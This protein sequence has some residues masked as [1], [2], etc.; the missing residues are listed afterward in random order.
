MA[1][2]EIGSNLNSVRIAL[3]LYLMQSVWLGIIKPQNIGI[4]I[5]WRNR[6]KNYNDCQ[7][8]YPRLASGIS[9]SWLNQIWIHALSSHAGKNT[10]GTAM[11]RD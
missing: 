9:I 8:Q 1:A 10:H 11:E 3:S 5:L 2:I 6:K 4:L 7:Y